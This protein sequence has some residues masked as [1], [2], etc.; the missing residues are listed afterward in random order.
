VSI[1]LIV[2]RLRE[3]AQ[4]SPEL[5]DA[6]RLY[7]VMLPLLGIAD[8][9]AGA[10]SLTPEAAREKMEQGLPLLCDL[11]LDFDKQAVSE[12]M[13]QLAAALEDAGGNEP[14][15]S[16]AARCIREAFENG[17]VDMDDLLPHIA[18]GENDAF[19]AAAERLDLEPGLLRVLAQNSLRPAL[20]AWSRQVSPMAAGIPWQRN[21]CF[22]C[23]AGALLAELQDDNQVKHLRCGQCGADWRV[24]RLQCMHCGNENHRTLGYLYAEGRQ[25]RMRVE[26]C[27][28]CKGY[29]K[30]IAAFT[31][32]PP[33]LLPVEDLATM[34]LDFAAE[35][36]GYSRTVER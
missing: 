27:E 20:Q 26:V 16:A 4:D 22:V 34:H 8:L 17:A 24:R 18:E 33:E 13:M 11:A 1:D 3:V 14:S 6:A 28:E 21:Y 7:S 9:H 19:C 12:L 2:R 23:G 15:R 5:E 10:V 25:A 32:T 31:P 29:I 36:R 30:V 35:E